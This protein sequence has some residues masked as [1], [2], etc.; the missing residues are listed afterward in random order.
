M[1]GWGRAQKAVFDYVLSA[2]LIVA[3]APVIAAIAVA[4]KLDSS[5]PVLFR[6]LRH[7]RD[8]RIFNVV[9]FRTM[10]VVEDGNDVRHVMLNHE[11]VTRVGRFLRR[12]GLDELPQL[13]NVLRNEM[14]LIGPRPHAIGHNEEFRSIIEGYGDRHKVKPGIGGWAQVN[15][16]R[17]SADTAAKMKTR[18]DYDLF[19]IENW[20]IAL[21]IKIFLMSGLLLF[22]ALTDIRAKDTQ[23]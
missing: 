12:T 21:D 20:S 13:V 2:F 8:H 10:T 9:K 18:V 5:G 7:G 22:R 4:I 17:G 6:Q 15:G 19:Y 3:T 11:R 23:A 16:C 1:T 14:S